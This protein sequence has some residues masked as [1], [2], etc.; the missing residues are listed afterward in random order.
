M[1]AHKLQQTPGKHEA[2][3][4]FKPGN[5]TLFYA[6]EFGA[7][8]V[9]HLQRAVADDGANAHAVSAGCDCAWHAVHALR[10]RRNAVVVGIGR[11]A[12]AA[13]LTKRQRPVEFR[14]A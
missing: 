6:A 1:H 4:L 11:Q 13:A 7:A 9:L 12:A 2:V 3:A 5:K 8:L 14:L 10:I